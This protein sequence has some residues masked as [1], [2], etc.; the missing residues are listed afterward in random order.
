MLWKARTT[1][2]VRMIPIDLGGA[3]DRIPVFEISGATIGGKTLLVTAG[4]DG[5]EYASID[6]AY[7]LIRTYTKAQF[8]GRLII[9]PIVNVPG[10]ECETS[11]NPMDN[12]HP[13]HVLKG[14]SDG[15]PTERLMHWV[16]ETY[17][18]YADVW[19]DM[20]GGYLTEDLVP[21][22]WTFQTRNVALGRMAE[23]LHAY[24]DSVYHVHQVRVSYAPEYMAR[25][26]TMYCISE[27]GTGGRRDKQE[28]Q[29]HVRWATS[30]MRFLGMV[31]GMA[32]AKKPL[33]VF[34]TVRIVRFQNNGVYVPKARAG[35]IV[36]KGEIVGTV[37]SYDI[38]RYKH[39]K[40]Q[41]S[42]TVLWCKIGALAQKGRIAVA[43]ASY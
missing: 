5:D 17:A 23:E 14:R 4:M 27:A 16:Q 30:I 3:V 35:K 28:V 7:W 11:F 32:K 6:A 8:R 26:G 1:S 2:G 13:V 15:K 31:G 19:L 12:M 25:Y 39:I 43:V 37:F 33:S 41:S 10:F 18:K 22:F 20:H 9:I 40:A 36:K 29:R 38:G 21:F 42:G 34:R 24:I